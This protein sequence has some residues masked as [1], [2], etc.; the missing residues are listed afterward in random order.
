LLASQF[1]S[2]IQPVIIMVAIPFGLT[3]AIAGHI[4]MGLQLTIVSIFGIVALSGIVVKDSLILIDFSIQL[5]NYAIQADNSPR[6]M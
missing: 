2:Y 4:I 6:N 5:H 1:R 3:G